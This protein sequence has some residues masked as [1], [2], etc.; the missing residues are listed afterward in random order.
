MC[1]YGGTDFE[2]CVMNA[3]G[4]NLVQ[5]TNNTVQELS[6]RWSVDGQKFFFNRPV[7]MRNQLFSINTDG[8]GTTQLT[9]TVG[10]NL[11]PAPGW[12]HVKTTCE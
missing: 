8:T 4:S 10:V 11:F 5:L 3:D 6:I 9:D 12:L 1:R 7:S 2:I